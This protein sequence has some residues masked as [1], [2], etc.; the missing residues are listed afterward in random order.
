MT[1]G[2]VGSGHPSATIQVLTLGTP[3]RGVG[4]VISR[5]MTGPSDLEVNAAGDY[6]LCFSLLCVGAGDV[7]DADDA[8]EAGYLL[9]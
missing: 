5:E 4:P 9:W 3:D 6:S 7:A 2:D 8:P 1:S